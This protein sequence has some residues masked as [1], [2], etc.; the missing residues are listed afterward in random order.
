MAVCFGFVLGFFYGL[1]TQVSVFELKE[2][3]TDRDRVSDDGRDHRR[4]LAGSGGGLPAPLALDG[5]GIRRGDST[6]SAGVIVPS[7]DPSRF[8]DGGPGSTIVKNGVPRC[9]SK[10]MDGAR[11]DGFSILDL[12]GSLDLAGLQVVTWLPSIAGKFFSF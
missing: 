2:I 5:D 12:V 1:K 3:P 7:G 6:S 10:K 11:V 4:T 8:G 9:I